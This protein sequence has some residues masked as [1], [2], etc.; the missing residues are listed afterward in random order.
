QDLAYTVRTLARARGF[1]MTAIAIVALGVGAT[2][3]AFWLTDFVLIRPLPFHDADRL[4]RIWEKRPGF[5]RMELSPA[6]YRDWKAGA[7]SC[8]RF[9]AYR[10]LS[11]NLV[12]GGEPQRLEGATVTADLLSVLGVTPLLG[13][14]FTDDDDREDAAPAALLSYRLWQS[15]FGGDASVIGRT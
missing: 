11:L 10:G 12:G 2:T 13:R 7:Q 14:R 15:Q 6:N 8:E 3:A 5:P 4:V 9:G 1:A